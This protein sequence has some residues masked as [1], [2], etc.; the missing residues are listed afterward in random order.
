MDAAE[1]GGAAPR[2]GRFSRLVAG[3]FAVQV[4]ATVLNALT[5]L[6]TARWLGPEG[7]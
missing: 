6:F 3:T 7:K 1:A 5:G 2:P 4:A